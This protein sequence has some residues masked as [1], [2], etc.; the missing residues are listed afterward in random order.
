MLLL[1]FICHF[2]NF[3]SFSLNDERKNETI[4]HKSAS[5]KSLTGTW[6]AV[7]SNGS[8]VVKS[9]VPGNIFTDLWH[10]NVIDDPYFGDNDV[11]YRWIGRENWIFKRTFNVECHL[12][13]KKRIIL[14]AYGLDTVSKIFLNGKLIGS[15]NNMFIRYIFDIKHILESNN[16]IVVSFR[17]PVAYAEE[18]HSEQTL[19]RYV[20]PP[21]CPPPVQ[22]GEC[23]VNYMRKTQSS[24]SWDWG[25]SFPTQGI[26]KP[27]EIVGFDTVLIRDVS[28]I[29]HFT[30]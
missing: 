23:H 22:N 21:T 8:I 24:F 13:Q 27:L 14:V 15:S 3:F 18:K 30:G 17:S 26:W 29:T 28:V 1:F 12:L 10:N 11:K 2:L 9:K 6:F 4:V 19:K 25:P 20:I 7:N 5:V 16:T